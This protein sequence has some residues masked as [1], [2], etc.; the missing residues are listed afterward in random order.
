MYRL[1]IMITALALM[2]SHGMAQN[3]VVNHGFE[4]TTCYMASG[5]PATFNAT[6]WYNPNTG[7]S[8]LYTSAQTLQGCH[9]V[10]FQEPGSA[11]PGVWQLPF[12]GQVMAGIIVYVE[13]ACYREFLQVPLSAPLEPGKP[14]CISFRVVLAE[15]GNYAIDRLGAA[16]TVDPVTDYTTSCVLGLQAQMESAPG[17]L[18]TDS[19]NWT[20]IEGEYVANGG[21][22]YI[23]LGNHVANDQVNMVGVEG[24]TEMPVAYYFIDD[25]V[26]E[27]C[28][29]STGLSVDQAGSGILYD[30]VTGMITLPAGTRGT[31]EVW[32]AGG[33]LVRSAQAEQEGGTMP[34][35]G[36]AAGTYIV[37][38][39]AGNDPVLRWS[40]IV[41]P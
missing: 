24:T 30:A 2:T 33:R 8:D 11:P 34:L 7:T 36:V 5:F 17:W 35:H 12:E 13:G 28:D 1:L 22:Q 40:R 37:T 26:V 15:H 3:L 27:P 38:L 19:V 4:D 16:L 23:T 41:V 32:D 29:I 10:E 20:L 18:L 39:R 9:L 25:V 31:L 21:E 6:D 14:Y